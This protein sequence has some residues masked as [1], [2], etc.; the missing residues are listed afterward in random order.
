MGM[1]RFAAA[2]KFDLGYGAEMEKQMKL[3][4]T[5]EEV[6]QMVEQQ[7]QQYGRV[8]NVRIT[9]HGDYLAEVSVVEPSDELPPATEAL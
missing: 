2:Q 4:F 1:R 7:C 3:S 5:R 9:P 8:I 6:R